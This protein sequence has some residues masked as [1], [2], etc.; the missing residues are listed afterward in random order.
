MLVMEDGGELCAEEKDQTRNIA[1]RKNSDDRA[2]R[3]VNL[4]V[5][6]VM[7]TQSE[8]VLRDFPQQSRQKRTRQSVSQGDCCLRHKAVYQHEERDSDEITK[9]RK[10][11][12]PERTA[13]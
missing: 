7:K 4:I 10:Q 5:V 9:S 12:L 6:K 8:D 11:H 1:P 13:D 2:D 3:S